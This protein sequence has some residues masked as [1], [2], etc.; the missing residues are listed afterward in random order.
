MPKP[1]QVSSAKPLAAH[2]ASWSA[3]SG[4]RVQHAD[5]TWVVGS[6]HRVLLRGKHIRQGTHLYIA[7]C[8]A[9]CAYAHHSC[10]FS[11]PSHDAPGTGR[12]STGRC[13]LGAARG[14]ELGL[15]ISFK[16]KEQKGR[17]S[18]PP[19]QAPGHG[20]ASAST[21]QARPSIAS[22]QA[23]VQACAHPWGSPRRRSREAG[24]S[25]AR[26]TGRRAS[27]VPVQPAAPPRPPCRAP[28]CWHNPRCGAGGARVADMAQVHAAAPANHTRWHAGPSAAQFSPQSAAGLQQA[29]L[30]SAAWTVPDAA[31]RSQ[32]QAGV[33]SAGAGRGGAP[34]AAPAVAVLHG[35]H[36][37][38][39]AKAV[40]RAA[41]PHD[42]EAQQ[43]Q[44]A[45][46]HD[47]RLARHVQRAPA[48]A[49]APRSRPPISRNSCR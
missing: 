3:D 24:Q 33:G 7:C 18:G 32:L 20:T 48:P 46:A 19:H 42:R 40:V 35:H 9:H 45:R 8:V 28:R 10:P 31:K 39:A 38:A 43:R 1:R 25:P 6:T 26:H 17:D 5:V 27:R 21:A 41:E 37:A 29:H 14:A 2:S 11:R 12:A 47:A 23:A 34:A 36:G 16:Q 15:S 13:G 49:R 30:Q 22:T 4:G 44:R